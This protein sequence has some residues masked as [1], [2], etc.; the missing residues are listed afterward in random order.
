MN[1]D[2]NYIEIREHYHL[3]KKLFLMLKKNIKKYKSFM[4]KNKNN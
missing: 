3:D 4:K 1:L 2:S